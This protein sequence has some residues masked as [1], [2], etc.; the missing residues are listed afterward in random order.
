MTIHSYGILKSTFEVRQMVF[1]RVSQHDYY[2]D[3]TELI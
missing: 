3:S 2:L 1:L